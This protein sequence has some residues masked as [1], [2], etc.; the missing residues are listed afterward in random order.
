MIWD[1]AQVNCCTKSLGDG[2]ILYH[3]FASVNM[4]KN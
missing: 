3:V 1:E 2:R 4:E